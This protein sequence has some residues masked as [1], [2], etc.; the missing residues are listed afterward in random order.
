[1]S[2]KYDIEIIAELWQKHSYMEAGEYLSDRRAIISDYKKITGVKIP[3]GTLNHYIIKLDRDNLFLSHH[4]STFNQRTDH[5]IDDATEPF[6][7]NSILLALGLDPKHFELMPHGRKAGTINHWWLD[8]A[9]LLERIRNGQIK[10]DFQK[11]EYK[12]TAEDIATAIDKI[13]IKPR[14]IDYTKKK[15]KGFLSIFL[16]D[17]HFHQMTSKHYEPHQAEILETMDLFDKE[18][19]VLIIG[20]DIFHVDSSAGNTYAGT[21]VGFEVSKLDMY[22]NAFNFHVPI[23]D[24]AIKTSERVKIIFIEGNHDRTTAFGFVYALSK[25]YPQ[26]EFDIEEKT[27]KAHSFKDVIIIYA[28]GDLPK[29]VERMHDALL[30]E[31]RQEMLGA[32]TVEVHLGHKHHRWSHEKAGTMFRGFSSPKLDDKYHYD[33]GFIGSKKLMHLYYYSDRAMKQKINVD[34]YYYIK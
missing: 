15:G 29:S 20:S 5:F 2:R 13:K 6:D 10:I 14:V 30:A 24:K 4:K 33:N 17:L 3:Y 31:Y 19:T 32:K 8:K 16:T 27:R 34:G 21:Q 25:M 22:N 7:E 12:L 28:H 9:G 1:M 23:I 11:R 18:E 26:I